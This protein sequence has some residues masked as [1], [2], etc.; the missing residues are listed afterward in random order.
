MTIYNLTIVEDDLETARGLAELVGEGPF[1]GRLVAEA[2][3]PRAFLRRLETGDPGDGRPLDIVCMDIELGIEA[4]GVELVRL[5]NA[6]SPMT[7][8]IYITGYI[9]NCTRVYRTE[10][11]YFLVKPVDSIEL[12]DALD[13]AVAALDAAAQSE[14]VLAVTFRGRRTMVDL[15]RV[16]YI[17]SV[18]RKVLIHC[19]DASFE[20]YAKLAALL[21]ELPD[22]FIQCHK[23]FLLNMDRVASWESGSVRTASGAEVPVSQRRRR[24]VHDAWEKRLL[25]RM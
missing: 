16:E 24:A 19:P 11:T 23:S 21:D 5:L 12:A 6:L 18:G 25:R 15:A 13:K 17:E 22:S 1:A 8:V 3:G 20:T 9:E 7:Q 4:D 10:H 2:V 14:R